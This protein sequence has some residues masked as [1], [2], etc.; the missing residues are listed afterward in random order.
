MLVCLEQQPY[1]TTFSK[2]VDFIELN[3]QSNTFDKNLIS[4]LTCALRV[5]YT[6]NFEDI[7][8]TK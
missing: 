2:I 3:Y 8:W 6:L 1:E 4:E 5:K 7:F